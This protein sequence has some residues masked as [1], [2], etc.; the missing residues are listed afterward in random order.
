MVLDLTGRDELTELIRSKPGSHLLLKREATASGVYDTRHI[1]SIHTLASRGESQDKFVHEKTGVDTDTKND[2]PA[3]T[4]FSIELLA[5]LWVLAER[6][7]K[8][9]ASR[10]DAQP[11]VNTL[12]ELLL[13]IGQMRGRAVDDDIGLGFQH[14]GGVIGDIDA[15]VSCSTGNPTKISA[16]FNRVTV[17]CP[18]QAHVLL[19]E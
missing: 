8:F 11:S 14:L 18:D 6:V 1:Y 2:D 3:F 9:L 4:S 5:E 19:F 16:D 10:D 7:G 15:Q 17:H 13:H 12:E